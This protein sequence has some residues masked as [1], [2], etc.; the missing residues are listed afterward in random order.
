MSVDKGMAKSMIKHIVTWNVK[1][2]SPVEKDAGIAQ[3]RDAFEG[4]R[5]KIPGIVHLEI[6]VDHSHVD[7][8]CDVVLY[9]EFESREAQGALDEYATHPE[10]LRVRTELEGLRIARHPVDY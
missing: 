1:G 5:G 2:A 10:H 7:Y 8:A 3:L 6:G 4:I 9:S